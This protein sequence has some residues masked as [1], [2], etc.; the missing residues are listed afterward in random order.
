MSLAEN[1]RKEM[2]DKYVIILIF[3][4]IFSSLYILSF[5]YPWGEGVTAPGM[6]HQPT[7]VWEKEMWSGGTVPDENAYFQW[8]WIYYTTG[9]TYVPLEEIGP[10]KIA[11]FSFFIGDSPQSS[12]F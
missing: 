6:P 5:P 12:Y 10:D 1:L 3:L 8:A 7:Q 2:K 11:R 9:K 4:F